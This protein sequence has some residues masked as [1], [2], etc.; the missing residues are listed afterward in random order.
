MLNV[1]E[2]NQRVFKNVVS[3]RLNDSH[4]KIEYVAH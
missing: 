2:I 1:H 3:T 4:K